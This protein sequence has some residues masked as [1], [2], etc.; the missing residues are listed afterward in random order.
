M[1]KENMTRISMQDN[2]RIVMINHLYL[3]GEKNMSNVN[4]TVGKMKELLKSLPDDME[5]IVPVC[6]DVTNPNII[7]SFL[8]VRSVGVLRHDYEPGPALCLAATTD[9]IDINT[10]LDENKMNERCEKLLF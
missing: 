6:P 10:L 4:L 7:Y 8:H 9:G 5:L 3:K 2:L 1:G